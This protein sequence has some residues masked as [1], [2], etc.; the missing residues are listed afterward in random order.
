MDP[1]RCALR[2]SPERVLAD[3]LVFARRARDYS[4]PVNFISAGL[5]KGAAEEAEL[6]DSDDEEKPVKQDEF[7]KDF[8]PKK[9]KTVASLL[10]GCD[11]CNVPRRS[12]WPWHLLGAGHVGL[13]LWEQVSQGWLCRA[14][15][16]LS[17]DVPGVL[18]VHRV[19]LTELRDC[20]AMVASAELAC[21]GFSFFVFRV[22]ILSPARKVL[23]EEPSL[24]WISAAGKDTQKESDR[25]FFRKWA[26]CPEG[27]WGRTLKV[28]CPARG[29]SGGRQGQ[30]GARSAFALLCCFSARM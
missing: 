20:P 1:M 7:P 26:T 21:L 17:G 8:G 13:S 9:L 5:K 25:S 19:L 15:F 14:V 27:A 10:K 11:L 2:S 3:P 18:V 6:E 29:R 30:G 4:A 23:Q 22:A 24:S 16:A 28:W 12:L